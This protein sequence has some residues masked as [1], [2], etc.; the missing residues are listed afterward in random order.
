[1]TILLI[2]V[3][4]ISYFLFIYYIKISFKFK[5]I[6]QPNNLSVHKNNIPTGAGIIFLVIFYFF[7]IFYKFFI[8][9]DIFLLQ[10]NL[11][12]LIVSLTF[13][14]IISFY[15]DVYNIHPLIRLFFQIT[16]IFF[17]TS[18]FNLELV[19]LPIKI[20]I[21]LI[22]YFWVYTI[23]IIN[24]TDGVDGFLAVNA[25][26]FFS[27]I[28][29]YFNFLDNVNFIYYISLIMI[30]VL[31]AYLIFNKPNAK[32]FMGDAGSIFIGFLIGFISIQTI[33]LGRFDIVVSLL[34][35][36]YIDCS[37]TIIKKVF[38]KQYPWTRL[39]DYFFLIPIKNKFSHKKVFFANCIYN[40]CIS[41]IILMQIFFNV[42]YLC[43]L[44]LL[45]AVLLL[46][47]FNSF[48]RFQGQN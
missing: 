4:I 5:L 28:F 26:T 3:F 21:F 20:S 15:D 47:Y 48:S 22:I 38:K 13:L 40:S 35:Y 17:C 12:I 43:L 29:L 10:K 31:L 36:T 18:L 30:P 37:L 16:T 32:I 46:L 14:S 7:L 27:C 42:K 23:N 41:A 11:F 19:S 1:M 33:I 9:G 34:A 45:L 8:P 39:F 44:S 2:T 25:L 6:D 24:F